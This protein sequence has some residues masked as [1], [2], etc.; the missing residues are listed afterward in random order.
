MSAIFARKFGSQLRG[1]D[2]LVIMLL[3]LRDFNAAFRYQVDSSVG[4][5]RHGAD[6]LVTNY[7]DRDSKI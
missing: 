2:D 6:D 7:Y 3:S 5:Y 4:N 1:L